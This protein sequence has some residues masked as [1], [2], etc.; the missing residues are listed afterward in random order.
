MSRLWSGIIVVQVAISALAVPIAYTVF[1]QMLEKRGT[2]VPFDGSQYA[3]AKVEMDR[4]DE[5]G[6]GP[7]LSEEEFAA[8]YR[9]RYE[10][11]RL[12]LE[13]EPRPSRVSEP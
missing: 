4:E 12:R 8:L 3:S 1:T 11:L 2:V 10:E 13:A 5:I 9:E 6:A 7:Q